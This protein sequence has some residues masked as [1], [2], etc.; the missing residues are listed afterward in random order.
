MNYIKGI[1]T[2]VKHVYDE[3]N[4]ATLSGAIDIIVIEQ[5]DGTLLSSPFHVRFGKINIFRSREKV[6]GVELNGEPVELKLKLGDAGEAF[7]VTETSDYVPDGLATSPILAPLEQEPVD[8]EPFSLDSDSGTTM[9]RKGTAE[10]TN[11][12]L[13]QMQA[14]AGLAYEAEVYRQANKDA[15]VAPSSIELDPREV[16][17]IEA[18]KRRQNNPEISWGWGSLPEQKERGQAFPQS[19]PSSPV[20]A[21]MA[22][23]QGRPISP[24]VL[25]SMGRFQLDGAQGGSPLSVS[26][27]GSLRG[28]ESTGSKRSWVGS[29]FNIF[30]KKGEM[31]PPEGGMFLSDIE[32]QGD[33][34]A[35]P[36]DPTEEP[37]S[38]LG[39]ASD[40]QSTLEFA[41]PMDTQEADNNKGENAKEDG[42]LVV[43]SSLDLTPAK[44]PAAGS[45]TE[46]PEA[47]QQQTNGIAAPAANETTPLAG[48]DQSQPSNPISASNA[49]SGEQMAT[50]KSGA[51]NSDESSSNSD[52]LPS[53]RK[54]S[55]TWTQ[56]D[57]P[58]TT[59]AALVASEVEATSAIIDVGNTVG[60]S[61]ESEEKDVMLATEGGEEV[62]KTTPSEGAPISKSVSY[63]N[64]TVI[65]QQGTTEGDGQAVIDMTDR[66][67]SPE[68]EFHEGQDGEA[69]DV[70]VE[71]SQPSKKPKSLTRS[72]TVF[73][74]TV[75]IP[76][77]T[78]DENSPRPE[79]SI[80]MSLC[81]NIAGTM[82]PEQTREQFDSHLVSFEE[83]CD[84]PELMNDANLVL[85]INGKYYDWKI[86]GPM[87]MSYVVF[88]QPLPQH[89]LDRLSDRYAQRKGWTSWLFGTGK[90]QT[91]KPA[92]TPARTDPISPAPSSPV[93][94]SASSSDLVDSASGLLYVPQKDRAQSFT[95]PI[96]TGIT[97]SPMSRPASLGHDAKEAAPQTHYRKTLRPTTEQLA[98]LNLKPGPNS[99]R[100]TVVTKLQGTAFCE[101]TIYRWRYDDKIV[102][103][104][105]DGTI[106]KSDA[107]GHILYALGKDWTH[108]GVA[109]LYSQIYNNGYKLLYLSSRAIGQ[110]DITRYYLNGVRQEGCGL[111]PGPVLLSPDRLVTSFHREVI[112]KKPEE[113]KIACLRDIRS[114][115]PDSYNPFYGG[116]GNRVTDD[117]SYRAVGMPLARIFIINP[118]GEIK[119][120]RHTTFRSSYHSLTELV[121]HMFPPLKPALAP[122]PP[123]NV[124]EE[125][126]TFNFW[127]APIPAVTD[128]E[129]LE[130]FEISSP[131]KKPVETKKPAE[132]TASQRNSVAGMSADKKS[133]DKPVALR[134]L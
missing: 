133:P 48:T 131:Q 14:Q 102:I 123:A 4:P 78:H 26:R 129:P 22:D 114:L 60:V 42:E 8:V 55:V 83:F 96:A 120:E 104:D 124:G 82:T 44:E 81:G 80:E 19:L 11:T 43:S 62:S 24:A 18:E 49:L 53:T 21:P 113:F 31:V 35:G 117:V 52:P 115:F 103:S 57:T 63:G 132:A 75:S 32:A 50:T 91:P 134:T 34:P 12:E 109:T 125:F 99:I 38:P 61:S 110:A 40:F 93:I 33:A 70:S 77:S 6:V 89:S 76:D 68:D 17:M 86:G 66:P 107:L 41:N 58:D 28:N 2:G 65:G 126:N 39:D 111:P 100:F 5:E 128:L 1:V 47:S 10:Y 84:R 64:V 85:R 29:I 101:S 9:S 90:Q 54:R 25:E 74:D 95:G 67:P 98:S 105:I 94:V 92:T 108:T 16:A 88:H 97:G 112:R 79:F 23:P 3:L 15:L 56:K 30:N 37:G 27:S 69:G 59:T 46:T 118:N 36:I 130:D 116:F 119:S 73:F 20:T 7:F 127:K 51:E 121:E 72:E 45:Q 106:T 87:I 122:A 71:G 13:L